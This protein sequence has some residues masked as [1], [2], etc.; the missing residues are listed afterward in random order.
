MNLSDVA[1]SD[2]GRDE[3][4]RHRQ[5]LRDAQSMLLFR[6]AAHEQFAVPLSLVS[7]LE[8]ISRASIESIGG[9]R[10]IQYRGGS[11]PLLD[12]SEISQVHPL[13]DQ[14][15]YFV[16]VYA[17]GGK[18]V[19]LLVSQIVDIVD[20]SVDFDEST[21]AQPGIIGST[22]LSS[23][24]TLIV[25]LYD[26]AKTSLPGLVKAP[27]LDAGKTGKAL[28]VDDSPFYRRQ[29][30]GY[31]KECGIEV[32]E[33]INGDEALALLETTTGIGL[34]LT[35]VEM[36]VMDG[37]E[38][39]R[40]IRSIEPLRHLPVVAITSL[41]GEEAE[42]RGREAGVDGYLVKLDREKILA[43]VEKLLLRRGI[44]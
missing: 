13:P 44:R 6:V 12:L 43:E 18:E 42:R 20:A 2:R 4:S 30:A 5:K 8:V 35:D 21:F 36:P 1:G 22:I 14:E 19:G 9:R 37:L 16:V 33:A 23:H 28:V 26:V 7:R 15:E 3:E 31:L 10:T 32:V 24:T 34:V 25:D 38:L 39:T 27:E 29:I 11:L 41:S 40:R 17:V